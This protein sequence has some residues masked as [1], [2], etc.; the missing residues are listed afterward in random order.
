[1]TNTNVI[2]MLIAIIL[3]LKDCRGVN[4]KDA[5]E[6]IKNELSN[7]KHELSNIKNE[8]AKRKSEE[9]DDEIN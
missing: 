4:H 3:A 8:L 7:I 6:E 2:L 5:L 9:I 1:M